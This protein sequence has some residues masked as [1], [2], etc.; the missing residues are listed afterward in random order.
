MATENRD[1]RLAMA[2]AKGGKACLDTMTPEERQARAKAAAEARWGRP[3]PEDVVAKMVREIYRLRQPMC[4]YKRDNALWFSSPDNLETP[5]WREYLV[6]TYG[7][8]VLEE[9]VMADVLAQ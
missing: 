5:R 4:L 1:R 3:R 9:D 8:G 2:G 6:G 7:V